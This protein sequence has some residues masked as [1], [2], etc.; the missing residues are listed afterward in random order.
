M[1]RYQVPAPERFA[2]QSSSSRTKQPCTDQPIVWIGRED[3]SANLLT[4]QN[5]VVGNARVILFALIVNL[6]NSTHGSIMS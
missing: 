3:R 5:K 1:T 2:R 4:Y 6:N